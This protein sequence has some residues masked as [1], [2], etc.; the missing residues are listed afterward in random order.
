VGG[1][2]KKKTENSTIKPVSTISVPCMKIQMPPA[3]DAHDSFVWHKKLHFYVK[4][5]S[6]L[7]SIL[8]IWSYY[9]KKSY[10]Y[11]LYKD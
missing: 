5:C 1:S 2:A 6:F 4:I 3:A 8:K 10:F 7:Y 9:Q 11:S